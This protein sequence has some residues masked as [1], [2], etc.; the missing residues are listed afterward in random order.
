MSEDTAVKFVPPDIPLS[1]ILTAETTAFREA[2]VENPDPIS[3]SDFPIPERKTPAL[4][5]G[6][7]ITA[8]LVL[9]TAAD[10]RNPYIKNGFSAVFL[11]ISAVLPR[12]IQPEQHFPGRRS[13]REAQTSPVPFCD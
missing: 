8:A 5:A 7:F 2:I 6:V 11:F 1:R 3:L 10:K 4:R 9:S 13:E 12:L